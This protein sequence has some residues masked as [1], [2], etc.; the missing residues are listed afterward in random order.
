MY[1]AIRRREPPQRTVL[2]QVNCF[3]QCEVVGSQISLDGVQPHDTRT[4]WCIVSS[5]SLVGEPLE[6]S[7]HGATHIRSPA[8]PMVQC[9][10]VCLS[11]TSRC[12]IETAEQISAHRLGLPSVYPTLC[13]KGI[14]VSP[15]VRLLPSRTSPALSQTLGIIDLCAIFGTARRPSQVLSTYSPIRRKFMLNLHC[16]YLLCILLYNLLYNKL[17]T[18]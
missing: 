5:T 9:L 15:K 10:S 18:I 12:S 17:T 13:Y 2:S 6:S 1:S 4:P 16:F 3:V 14:R 8:Y 11:V 7:W